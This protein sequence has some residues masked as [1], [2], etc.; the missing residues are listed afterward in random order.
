MVDRAIFSVGFVM[1]KSLWIRCPASRPNA[2]L[3]LICFPHAGGNGQA[4]AAWSAQ[5]S[6]DIE[7][8]AVTLPGRGYRL[9]EPLETRLPTLA[10][11]LAERLQP[12]AHRPYALFGHSMGGLLAYAVTRRQAELGLRIPEHLFLAGVRPPHLLADQGSMHGR[13][14]K[15]LLDCLSGLGGIPPELA[16]ESAMMDLFLPIIRADLAACETYRL[17]S[18]AP[19]DCPLSALAAT[20]DLLAPPAQMAAWREYTRSRFAL[21]IVEGDHFF[22]HG[23]SAAVINHIHSVLASSGAIRPSRA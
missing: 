6:P 2:A 12:F 13:D 23:S 9:A 15:A 19:V 16:R 10:R 21:N 22:V 17:R 7:L 4:Y 14:D 8:H 1:R 18:P 5:L 20:G 3:S 11:A